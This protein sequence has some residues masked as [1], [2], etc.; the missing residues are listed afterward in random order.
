MPSSLTIEKIKAYCIELDV[1]NLMAGDGSIGAYIDGKFTTYC[2]AITWN[3]QK[4]MGKKI[5]R[6][7]G[8]RQAMV[9]LSEFDYLSSSKLTTRTHI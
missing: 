9:S 2:K 5:T 1:S 8:I 6:E 3:A 4:S 7:K